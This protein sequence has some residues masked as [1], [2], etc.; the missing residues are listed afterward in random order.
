MTFGLIA[1]RTQVAHLD[2]VDLIE[3][4]DQLDQKTFQVVVEMTN[5]LGRVCC[6]TPHEEVCW[7]LCVPECYLSHSFWVTSNI[8]L[9]DNPEWQRTSIEPS[10]RSQDFQQARREKLT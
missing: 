8:T 5:Y 1:N 9:K 3:T 7:M 2:R 4:E 6:V 10:V